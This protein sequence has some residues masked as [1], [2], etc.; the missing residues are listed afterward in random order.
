MQITLPSCPLSFHLYGDGLLFV[1]LLTSVDGSVG[2]GH[3]HRIGVG[4]EGGAHPSE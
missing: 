2:Y 4:A 1:L 3:E